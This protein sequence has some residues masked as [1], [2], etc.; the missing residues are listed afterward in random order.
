VL[1]LIHFGLLVALRGSGFARI[2]VEQ[3]AVAAR[4]RRSGTAADRRGEGVDDVSSVCTSRCNHREAVPGN[5]VTDGEWRIADSRGR[6]TFWSDSF[7]VVVAP[8]SSPDACSSGPQIPGAD[9]RGGT[10]DRGAAAH[11]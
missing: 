2:G 1:S 8:D 9:Y 4:T 5:S 7:A 6:G 11:H 3:F 10:A